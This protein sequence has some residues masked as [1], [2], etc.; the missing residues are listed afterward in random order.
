MDVPQEDKR[1]PS[2][3]AMEWVSQ[4]TSVALMMVLPA[5]GG[6]WLDQKLDSG[7]WFLVSGAVVGLLMGMLQLLRMLSGSRFKSNTRQSKV[8]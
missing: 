2:A 7:W 8:K 5:L 1:P 6:W 4:I 3:A